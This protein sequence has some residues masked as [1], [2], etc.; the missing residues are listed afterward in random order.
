MGDELLFA[1]EV[2]LVGVGRVARR[3]ERLEPQPH[4]DDVAARDRHLAP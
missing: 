2:A 4:L 1:R 3:D